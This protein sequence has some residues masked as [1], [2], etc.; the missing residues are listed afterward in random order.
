MEIVF[1]GTGGGRINLL[2]QKRWTG[3]F[4]INGSLNIH[5]DPGPGALVHGLECGQNPTHLG[6]LILS[7]AHIDHC[8][9]ANV[10]IEAMSNHALGKGGILIGSRNALSIGKGALT[11]FHLSKLSEVYEARWG[12]SKTFKT[13]KGGFSIEI[14]KAMHEEESTFGFRLRMDG[15]TI[16]YTSDTEYFEGMERQYSGCDYLILNAMKPE[17]DSYGRHLTTDN[18][19]RIL[20]AAKPNMALLSHMGMKMLREGPQKEAARIEKESGARTLAARDG[21]VL[22]PGLEKF[23]D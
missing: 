6:A 14:L 4:R 7:H 18:A 5:V 17:A 13:A 1:L 3:G 21:M 9:D 22:K 19:I 15:F 16:G 23:L 20:K 10:L 11:E 2:L 12:E 8:S